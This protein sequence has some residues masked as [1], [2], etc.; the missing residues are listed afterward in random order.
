MVVELLNEPLL[1]AKDAARINRQKLD[2][3]K[4]SKIMKTLSN[5]NR[6]EL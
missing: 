4:L 6:L 2:I 5:P 1:F 3:R